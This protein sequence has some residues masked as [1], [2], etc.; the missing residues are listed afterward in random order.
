VGHGGE[1]KNSLPHVGSRSRC[2]VT[3]RTEQKIPKIPI[4]NVLTLLQFREDVSRTDGWTLTAGDQV[5]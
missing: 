5:L 1:D 2:V 4:P 3:I